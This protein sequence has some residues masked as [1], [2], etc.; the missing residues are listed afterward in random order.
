[1]KKRKEI[2]RPFP[3]SFYKASITLVPKIGKGGKIARTQ[4]ISYFRYRKDFLN[5]TLCPGIRAN[6]RHLGMQETKNLLY[7]YG[8]NRLSGEETHTTGENRCQAYILQKTN[9]Q[10]IQRTQKQSRKQVTQCKRWAQV[11]F[12][13]QFLLEE[14]KMAKRNL[15]NSSSSFA[16]R[17]MPIQTTLRF[18]P[19]QNNQGQKSY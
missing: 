17:G 4:A 3:I 8:N 6:N 2:E 9:N 19:S 18:N 11:R 1:M 12:S 10:N 5:K 15:R 14:I 16:I 7:S 13:T